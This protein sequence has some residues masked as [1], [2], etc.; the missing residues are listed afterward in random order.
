MSSQGLAP[1]SQYEW[2]TPFQR[3]VW[4]DDSVDALQTA[5]RAMC[6]KIDRFTSA[7]F[8]HLSDLYHASVDKNDMNVAE[9]VSSF[10]VEKFSE[11]PDAWLLRG[12][13]LRLTNQLPEALSAV[14]HAILLKESKAT[15]SE[16]AAVV[17]ALGRDNHAEQIAV[18][19][20]RRF[21]G[22]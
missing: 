1:G 10:A 13:A 20:N 14:K 21:Q 19:S 22:C 7:T 5:F 2:F 6:G 11:N 16:L 17:H 9:W 8:D 4:Q 12:R 18:Y 15:L 3:L